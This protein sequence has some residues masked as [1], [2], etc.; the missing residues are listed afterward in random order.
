LQISVH[1]FSEKEGRLGEASEKF[2]VVKAISESV[3]KIDAQDQ[4]LLFLLL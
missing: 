3:F 1:G 2:C 4:I